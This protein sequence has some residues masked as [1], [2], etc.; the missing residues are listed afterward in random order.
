MKFNYTKLALGVIFFSLVLGFQN[1]SNTKFTTDLASNS[2]NAATGG[3]DPA[4]G[5]SNVSNGGDDPTCRPT[6]V[7]TSSIVK[8]LFVVDAS[9]SNDTG[10]DATDPQ[11]KWRL[12]TLNNFI[13][14]YSKNKNFYFGLISFQDTSGKVHIQMNNQAV[15]TNDMNLVNAGVASFTKNN[16]G[17]N[18]PYRAALAMTKDV[19]S[20]DLAANP[21]Q[22]AAYVTVMI[23]DGQATDYDSPADV[24]PDAKAIRNLAPGQISLNSIF[25]YPA[26]SGVTPSAEELEDATAY[27]RNIATVGG[28]QLLT[29]E[30][31]SI[32]NIDNVIQVPG[33]S[34]Q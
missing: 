29:A 6:T 30:S 22:N 33:M 13:S 32:L 21:N 10:S 16:D 24:I 17:G 9:G 34:C 11:K 15:F 26:V 2:L 14:T 25:Y 5:G 12:S 18:T 20:A 4:I 23:S 3:N 27:L 1:C 8:V 31:N 28:G 7:S 19:I